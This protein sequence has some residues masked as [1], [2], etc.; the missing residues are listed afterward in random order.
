MIDVLPLKT[1]LIFIDVH[2]YPFL[3]EFHCLYFSSQS[4]IKILN[5]ILLRLRTIL[6]PCFTQRQKNKTFKGG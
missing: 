1:E 4:V 3:V 6:S 2:S 5:Y